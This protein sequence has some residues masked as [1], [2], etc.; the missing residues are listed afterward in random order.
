MARKIQ[1]VFPSAYTLRKPEAPIT[2]TKEHGELIY[3]SKM[4]VAAEVKVQLRFVPRPELFLTATGDDVLNRSLAGDKLTKISFAKRKT[5]INVLE[6]KLSGYT[7][8]TIPKGWPVTGRRQPRKKLSKVSFHLLNFPH[9]WG[10]VV[11]HKVTK[12]QSFALYQNTFQYGKWTITL[13][14]LPATPNAIAQLQGSG[15]HAITHVG[16]FQRLDG[17]TFSIAEAVD[18]LAA[19]HYFF[20]FARGAW[21]APVLV[22][23]FDKANNI[24]WEEWGARVTDPWKYTR[25]WFDGR[26][27]N[28]LVSAFPGFLRKW[29]DPLWANQLRSTIY[30]YLAANK[31]HHGVD[32]GL[33]LT[34]VALEPF[35]YHYFIKFKK[36]IS[37]TKFKKVN[38]KNKIRDLLSSIGVPI[39]VPSKL[40]KLRRGATVHGW[41]NGPN[42]L[43]SL[44]NNLVHSRDKFANVRNLYDLE[45]EAWDLG[46]WY[47]ELVLLWLMDYQDKY[48]C[49]LIRQRKLNQTHRL[50]WT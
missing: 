27:G 2:V 42:A 28:W 34:Q 4:V 48:W 5:I 24:I 11:D 18:M 8:E 15:G 47:L 16:T 46:L 30:Y 33:V 1:A 6:S 19:L 45:Y 23:G 39:Q 12:T 17:M 20:S 32:A 40:R 21:S 26:H 38:A 10:S 44:R 31:P 13:S 9:C 37:N 3:K 50:P 41:Q 36:S 7:I 25:S 43:A 35:A 29:E 49:R 14:S 22:S